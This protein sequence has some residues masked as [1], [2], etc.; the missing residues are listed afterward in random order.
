MV[1]TE[2]RNAESNSGLA[3][4][5]I[6]VVKPGD[7]LWSIAS[8]FAGNGNVSSLEYRLYSELGTTSIRPGQEIRIP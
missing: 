3:A 1:F 5:Q 2:M 4:Q 8:R 7:T 6:Y